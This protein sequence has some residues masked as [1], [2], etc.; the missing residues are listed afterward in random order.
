MTI[1]ENHAGKQNGIKDIG[2]KE[3]EKKGKEK[4]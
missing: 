4:E 2:N 1:K 3:S